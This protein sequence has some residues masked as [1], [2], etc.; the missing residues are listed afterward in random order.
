MSKKTWE[1]TLFLYLRS[2]VQVGDTY[3][4]DDASYMKS[5]VKT[6]GQHFEPER[7]LP[8]GGEAFLFKVFDSFLQVPRVLKVP[9]P[10][11]PSVAKER[12]IRSVRIL[13]QLKSDYF[14]KVLYLS[15]VPFFIVLE[16]IPGISLRDWC[17]SSEYNLLDGL[18][19]FR[20]TLIAIAL[21]HE[22]GVTHRDIRP[23]NIIITPE[24]KVKIIDF[25]LCK[26]SE[27][28]RLTVTKALGNKYYSPP[29]QMRDAGSV[30]HA[31]AD[32]YSL[33]C[34]L[35]FICTKQENEHGKKIPKLFEFL[36]YPKLVEFFEKATKDKPSERFQ[37]AGEMLTKYRKIIQCEEIDFS[38][39]EK[40]NEIIFLI[41]SLFFLL[42][43][44]LYYAEI[45]TNHFLT[46]RE[47]KA[48]RLMARDYKV[49]KI[50]AL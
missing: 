13:A 18:T 5:I 2:A 35:Y 43:G 22:Q 12:F 36:G 25:G 26:T 29:E 15:S 30:V 23:D 9:R 17:F 8:M 37:N 4:L 3:D 21:L 46:P 44:D 42:S 39:D 20:E 10:D 11:L 47:L 50:L 27:N 7:S 31:N 28:S 41:E 14:P 16:W 45:F 49:K 34:T 6:C 33:A 1:E 48:L 32:V 24:G 40:Q 38:Q 19:F